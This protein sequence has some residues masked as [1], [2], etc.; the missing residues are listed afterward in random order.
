MVCKL[1]LPHKKAEILKLLE[2]KLVF[3]R[4]NQQLRLQTLWKLV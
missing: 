1:A 3:G 4:I 2:W